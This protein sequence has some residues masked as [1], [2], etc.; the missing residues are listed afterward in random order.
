MPVYGDTDVALPG[1]LFGSNHVIDTR[2]ANADAAFGTP[3]YVAEGDENQFFSVAAAGRRLKG[4]LIRSQVEAASQNGVL[5]TPG[6][7]TAGVKA[8]EA[9]NVLVD[10]EAYVPVATAV[11]ANKPAYLT[12]AGVWT[13]VVGSNVLTPFYFRSSTTGA[14]V[15]RIE[16]SR[17]AAA[18]VG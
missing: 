3:A 14:G 8:K 15:A 12:A 1:M 9:G 13:D 5:G 4:V 6:N 16:V 7:G 17:A 10:G 2:I 11:T 18:V